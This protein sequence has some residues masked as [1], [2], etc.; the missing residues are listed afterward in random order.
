MCAMTALRTSRYVSASRGCDAHRAVMS[1][2]PMTP[3]KDPHHAC[4]LSCVHR[5]RTRQT[6]STLRRQSSHSGQRR[7]PALCTGLGG[8]EGR[9]N[10]RPAAGAD[11]LRF[12]PPQSRMQRTRNRSVMT[13]LYD[14]T[15]SYR[16]SCSVRVEIQ[17]AFQ[18]NPAACVYPR[19]PE[20]Q[21]H[22]DL[23]PRLVESFQ[24]A[25]SRL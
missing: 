5:T 12:P 16:I 21:E 25:A 14:S 1:T 9:S 15:A 22:V 13:G 3:P 4:F 23:T 17:P 8:G 20:P 19:A 2:K 6:S 11:S 10:R 18:L 24:G 7:S